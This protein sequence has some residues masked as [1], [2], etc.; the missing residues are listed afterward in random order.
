M[1][2]R[3]IGEESQPLPGLLLASASPRRRQLM[4]TLGLPFKA[5]VSPLD[6]EQLEEHYT[7]PAEELGRWLAERKAEAALTLPEA[8]GS[9]IVAADTTVILDG[10]SQ[11]KPRDAAHARTI[12]RRLRGRWHQVITGVAIAFPASGP[13]SSDGSHQALI[14]SSQCVTPVL[15]RSYS[16]EEIEAYIASGDPLDK[17]G[18][19]GIQNPNFQLPEQ[20][21]GCYLNVVG[22]PLCTLSALLQTG[23]FRLP[24]L[25]QP[26]SPCPWSERCLLQPEKS[27]I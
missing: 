7:G 12:L 26:G 21:A 15:M 4:A 1:N 20:I 19:Y 2:N 6:E 17:A 14:R 16:D 9:L 23:G 11:G 10:I 5:V 3:S 24:A 25:V 13:G 27:M 22:F 8:A 18:A